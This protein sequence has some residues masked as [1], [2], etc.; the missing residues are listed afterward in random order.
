MSSVKALVLDVDGILTDGGIFLDAEGRELKRFHTRDG[1]GIKLALCVGWRV[2]FCTARESQPARYRAQE[3]GAEWSIGIKKKKI[4]LESWIQK[5]G[6]TWDE[7]AFMGDDL[8]D[9]A[10]LQSVG[11]PI[12]VLDGVPEVQA[13]ARYTTPVPGGQGAVRDAVTWLLKEH[14]LYQQAVETFLSSPEGFS[15]GQESWSGP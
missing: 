9:L 10:V 2:L 12:T 8:Q 5:A 7:L 4:F 6:L 3:M 15:L 13:V 11:W 14:D 1:V